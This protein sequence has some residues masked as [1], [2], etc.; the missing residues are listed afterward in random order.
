M[1]RPLGRQSHSFPL[2]SSLSRRSAP[3]EAPALSPEEQTRPLQGPAGRDG[4]GALPLGLGAEICSWA[5]LGVTEAK[6]HRHP[7]EQLR[8]GT[9]VRQAQSFC[10]GT[11]AA[12]HQAPV[13]HAKKSSLSSV[14]TRGR[15]RLQVDGLVRVRAVPDACRE[16]GEGNTQPCMRHHSRLLA[17]KVEVSRRRL[18]TTPSRI[19]LILPQSS[20]RQRRTQMTWYD[21]CAV[22]F[23]LCR[24]RAGSFMGEQRST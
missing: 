2:G 23:A 22:S 4:V 14:S 24:F 21:G 13:R 6:G 17:R 8:K 20:L 16:E 12:P 7:F 9:G 18:S 10:F 15:C 11:S 3:K 1:P 5:L 19:L